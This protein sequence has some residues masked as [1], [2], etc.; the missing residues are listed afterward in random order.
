MAEVI[1][2]RYRRLRD[3]GK[4]LP[5]LLIVDG[6]EGQMHVAREVIVDRLGLAIPIAGL[7]KDDRHRTNELLTFTP[8]GEI[9]V[10]QLKPTDSLFHLLE[11]IQNEVHRFA[12]TFH[13]DKRSRGT[14][15]TSLTNIPGIGE[16]TAHELLLRYG[17]VKQI[18][19]QTLDDLS[20]AIGAAKARLVYDHL[21]ATE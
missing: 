11:Q 19:I 3:E 14:F 1:E 4:P 8:A 2:R 10:V 13:K 21:H 9:C 6:G 5:D 20:S 15:R 18:G 17:S 7:A 16:K 12:I